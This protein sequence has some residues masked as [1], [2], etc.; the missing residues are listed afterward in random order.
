MDQG[1]VLE[2]SGLLRA[3]IHR[4]IINEAMSIRTL[5]AFISYTGSSFPK[6]C[7]AR[8]A[9]ERRAKEKRRREG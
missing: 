8:G 4:G 1:T 2:V 5:K 9:E 6:A 3:A 7:P